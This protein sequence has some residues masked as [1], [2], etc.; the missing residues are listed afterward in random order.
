[1]GRRHVSWCR[2]TGV[3][4]RHRALFVALGLAA[5]VAAGCGTSG[6]DQAPDAIV[7]STSTDAT[8]TTEASVSDEPT[9]LRMSGPI[10]AGRYRFE[11]FVPPLDFQVADDAWY[12]GQPSATFVG[13]NRYPT[14]PAAYVTVLRPTEV[15]GSAYPDTEPVSPDLAQW[16]HDRPGF[17]AT[18]ITETTIDGHAAKRF[19]VT[20]HDGPHLCDMDDGDQGGCVR[21]AP[22]EGNEDYRF[23]DGEQTRFWVLDLDGPVIIAVSDLA[24][25][26]V[27]FLPLGEA[28]VSSMRFG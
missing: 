15:F 6:D 3:A 4:P 11:G 7:T 16:L 28:V 27:D 18:D 9:V 8:A 12:A 1:M 22:I 13:V 21:I 10:A 20:V 17:T 25:G 5:S 14:E 19:D 26:F 23:Y 24:A 2:A